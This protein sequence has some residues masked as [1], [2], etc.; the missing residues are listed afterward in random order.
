MRGS[1]SAL[2]LAGALLVLASLYLPWEKASSGGAP[3]SLDGWLSGIGPPAALSALVLASL[4]AVAVA[5]PNLSDRLALGLCALL[6]G[7]FTVAVAAAA[8]SS[9]QRLA[10]GLNALH[11]HYAYGAYVGVTGAAIALLAAGAMRRAELGRNRSASRVA[12][13]VFVAGLLVSFLLPWQ[14]FALPGRFTLLGIVSPAAVIAVVLALCLVAVSW[15]VDAAAYAERAALAAATALF[16]GAA[17]SS[18]IDPGVR[19]YGAWVGLAAAAAILALP[20]ADSTRASRLE[21][22]SWPAIATCG[23]AALLV[24]SLFLPWQSACYARGRGFGSYS[25]TCVSANG[26]TF[27]TGAAAAA[28]A[29][30]LVVVALAPRRVASSGVLAA[31]VALLVATLGF[32][33]VGASGGGVQTEFGYGSTLGFVGAGLLIVLAVVRSRPPALDWNRVPVRLAPIA[34]CA[35]YLALVVLPW[36]AVLPLH[37]QSALRVG[38]L[39]WLTIAAALLAVWL[40]SEWADQIVGASVNDD[41]LVLIPLAMLA[42][43]APDL[44]RHRDSGITWGG[45]AVVVLC[46]LLAQLGRVEQREGL[47][48]LRIPEILRVDRL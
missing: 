48:R 47:E 25:G 30:G 40:V 2:V 26:W 39:S 16:T 20:S 38:P 4:A 6:T 28:L 1:W 29:I 41:R 9:A 32:E 3:L 43:V 18:H 23:A 17:L 13:L 14:R 45:G 35:T 44:I 27:T 19:A 33:L 22:P 24:T 21:L 42:L 15:R 5:R 7:Y 37:W 31:G 46:L 36:W 8:R 34:A 10:V 11:F 12:V